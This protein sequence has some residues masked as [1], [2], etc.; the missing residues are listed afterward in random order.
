MNSNVQR[1]DLATGIPKDGWNALNANAARA[2]VILPH[3]EKVFGLQKF[4][5]R[6]VAPEQLWLVYTQPGTSNIKF[7]LSC[8]EGSQGKYPLFIVPTAPI[9][10]LT[11]ELLKSPMEALCN[12]L[13]NE[14]G[15]RKQRV[16]S[17]FSVKSVAQAF[18]LAWEE[19]AETN[20]IKEPYYDAIF[21]MC[22]KKTL[23]PPEPEVDVLRLADDQDAETIGVL[24]R[25]FAATS[26][27]LLHSP[28]EQAFMDEN[29]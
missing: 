11:P 26:V 12:A 18:A 3:A 5:P 10:E 19:L 16:F 1:F 4:I 21:T 6:I 15:F 22:S 27:C 20:C 8:T 24:C 13:L 9:A 2:N 28:L 23:A 7:I 14:P 25:E 29:L 17:V